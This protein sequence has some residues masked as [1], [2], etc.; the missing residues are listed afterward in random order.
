[1]ITLNIAIATYKPEGIAR[2]AEA[3]L[4]HIEG[5]RYV[6]S[7]QSHDDAPV[8]EALKRDDVEIHRFDG[9]GQSANRNNSVAMCKADIVMPSDDDLRFFPEGISALKDIYE[10]HPDIDFISFKSVHES[11]V[12]YPDRPWDLKAQFPKNYYVP[13]FELSFKRTAGLKF[14]PELGLNSPR[15]HG[16]EDEMLL[17]SALRRGLNCWFFPITVCEHDHPSTGTKAHFTVENLRASGCVIA[18]ARGWQACLRVPLKAW[19]VWRAGQ[20]SLWRA[21]FYLTQ[22]AIESRGV[23]KRNHDSLW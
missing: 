6:V 19:R 23:L 14:C 20:S 12:C 7:W 21:L 11:S 3:Q 17:Q 15:M 2:L 1:M 18:L 10:K 22:G 4:P 13:C 8:P 16:G 9:V 5:V